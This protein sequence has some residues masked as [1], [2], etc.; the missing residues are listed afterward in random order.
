MSPYWKEPTTRPCCAYV[1]RNTRRTPQDQDHGRRHSHDSQFLWPEHDFSLWYRRYGSIAAQANRRS[2]CEGTLTQSTNLPVIWLTNRTPCSN[3]NSRRV[4]RSLLCIFLPHFKHVI[5]A[6]VYWCWFERWFQPNYRSRF[7][8]SKH[9]AKVWITSEQIR[10]RNSRGNWI[11]LYQEVQLCVWVFVC[12]FCNAF[13]R[14][15]GS[16]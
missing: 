15:F 16:L 8:H 10:W 12:L 7:C 9:K 5:S 14:S 1:T 3:N 4:E 6:T 2:T 11:S 13:Q